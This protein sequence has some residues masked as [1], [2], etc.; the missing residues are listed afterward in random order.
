MRGVRLH[1][2][3]ETAVPG[4]RLRAFQS[5]A[6]ELMLSTSGVDLSNFRLRPNGLFA[7]SAYIGTAAELGIPGSCFPRVVDLDGNDAPPD[8]GPGG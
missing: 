7:H 6:N 1:V 4:S 3:S 5:S 8:C 2:D